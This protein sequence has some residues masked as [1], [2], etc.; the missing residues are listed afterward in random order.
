MP[1]CSG[2]WVGEGS[3][4]WTGSFDDSNIITLQRE[5]NGYAY[6][7]GLDVSDIKS[8][9]YGVYG[10]QA[11]W[12]LLHGGQLA[13]QAWLG[14]SGS[15]EE[16]TWHDTARQVD[17]TNE[18][19]AANRV[20]IGQ[21]QIQLRAMQLQIEQVQT[22]CNSISGLVNAVLTQVAGV[23]DTLIAFRDE[24]YKRLLR[25]VAAVSEVVNAALLPIYRVCCANT[26]STG[27]LGQVS[28]APDVQTSSTIAPRVGDAVTS[29][30]SDEQ[31]LSVQVAELSAYGL[32]HPVAGGDADLYYSSELRQ[33]ISRPYRNSGQVYLG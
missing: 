12:D 25:A 19:V 8:Q 24:V 13:W 33:V 18:L 10:F 15:G 20:D 4:T 26:S 17:G 6:Q 5:T 28:V 2:G 14:A 1:N 21:I 29:S 11:S 16:Y 23:R 3:G 7:T 9:V 31:G 30:Y 32:F 22:T 27:Q